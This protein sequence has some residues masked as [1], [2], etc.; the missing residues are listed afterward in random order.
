MPLLENA[1]T[2]D[3]QIKNS[4]TFFIVTKPLNLWKNFRIP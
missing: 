4:K 3:N 1:A 2:W